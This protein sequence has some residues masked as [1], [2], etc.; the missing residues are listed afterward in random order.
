MTF[1]KQNWIKLAVVILI[2]WAVWITYKV[3]LLEA[4]SDQYRAVIEAQLGR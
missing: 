3:I 2:F 1:L 4:W